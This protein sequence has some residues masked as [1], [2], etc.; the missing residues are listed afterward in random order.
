MLPAYLLWTCS[1]HFFLRQ[2]LKNRYHKKDELIPVGSDAEMR[3]GYY[4][5]EPYASNNDNNAPDAT[6]QIWALL[7]MPL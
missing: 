2:F 3:R 4:D 5:Y 6:R 1:G 7:L